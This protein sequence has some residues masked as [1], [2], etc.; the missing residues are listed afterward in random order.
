MSHRR[1]HATI[2]DLRIPHICDIM[3]ALIDVG[4]GVRSYI[5]LLCG[6]LLFTYNGTMSPV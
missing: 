4:L 6:M 3:T 5:A 2:A 1:Q